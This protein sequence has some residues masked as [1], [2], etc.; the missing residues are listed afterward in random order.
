MATANKNTTDNRWDNIVVTPS[1]SKKQSVTLST[2][3]TYVDRDIL[4]E[5]NQITVNEVT[6]QLAKDKLGNGAFKANNTTVTIPA[7][8]ISIGSTATSGSYPINVAATT[9]TTSSVATA[10]GYI[11]NGAAGTSGTATASGSGS[12]AQSTLKNGS[13]TISS[14][15]TVDPGVTV[16]I[17]AGYYPT[18]RTVK[19]K[20]L[21]DVTQSEAT[22]VASLG[23]NTDGAG[24]GKIIL[25]SGGALKISA[26]YVPS[27][28]YFS[29]AGLV[30][31]DANITASEASPYIL[32]GKTAYDKNGQLITGSIP[33]KTSS[34]LSADGATVTV[35][36]GYY[37]EAAT[38]SIASTSRT[39]GSGAASG[40][41]SGITL[42]TKT[43]TKPSSGA[44]ITVTGSGSVSTGNGYITEGSTS[45]NTATAYYPVSIT[46]AQ[47]KAL[48]G[49]ATL[50]ASGTVSSLTPGTV[51]V[52]KNTTSGKIDI[53]A[54]V[55]ASGTASATTSGSGYAEAGSTTGSGSVSGSKTVTYS[56]SEA[57]LGA[58]MTAAALT[59][60][61][62]AT[63]TPA[64]ATVKAKASTVTSATSGNYYITITKDGVTAGSVKHSASVTAGYTSGDSK[65]ATIPT[66]ANVTEKTFYF[67]S[68]AITGSV[69]AAK[70]GAT[71]GYN[72]PTTVAASSTVPQ[73]KMTGNGSATSGSVYNGTANAANKYI[74]YYTGTYT[75]E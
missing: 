54:T 18:A 31:D 51:S 36:A 37:A 48:I 16:T 43:T 3:G 26:G 42:G 9:A 72:D 29:L 70:S 60:G 22:A 52:A 53:S 50:G 19:A 67:A 8:N 75:I 30:P 63:E 6:E 45:S 69:A 46:A 20:A 27:D 10:S 33:T 4:V 15:S 71:T 2:G 57:D 59:H 12:V 7:A 47:A 73:L 35:P 38:K 17:G 24:E 65:E 39:A 1:A 21:S 28:M 41:A 64:T 68:T 56:V 61:N 11:A 34:N 74:N 25:A 5:V 55:T 23:T 62:T 44:Y 14:G 49:N 58:K 32:S 40:T 13:T 66:S